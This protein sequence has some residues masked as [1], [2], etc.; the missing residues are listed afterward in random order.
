M[1][2][3]TTV[4]Q[5]HGFINGMGE[6]VQSPNMVMGET[7]QAATIQKTRGSNRRTER[8]QG[9]K[10]NDTEGPSW[11][12]NEHLARVDRNDDSGDRSTKR[13]RTQEKADSEQAASS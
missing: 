13:A 8:G 4:P 7:L 3:K 6:G 2:G 5:P 1:V 11:P 9:G 12:A 10:S